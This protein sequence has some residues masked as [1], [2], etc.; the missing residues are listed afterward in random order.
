MLW[1]GDRFVH[2]H[3]RYLG[4]DCFGRPGGPARKAKLECKAHEDL[5]R[6]AR[7]DNGNGRGL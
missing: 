5:E 4:F 3:G 2:L 6:I 7:M 1:P